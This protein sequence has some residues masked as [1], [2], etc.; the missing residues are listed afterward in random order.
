MFGACFSVSG[1]QDLGWEKVFF[2]S[3]S[4]SLFGQDEN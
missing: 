4:D 2:V 3:F 1:L